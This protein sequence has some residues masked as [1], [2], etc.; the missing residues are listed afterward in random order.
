MKK[1]LCTIFF[2]TASG[3]AADQ[4]PVPVHPHTLENLEACIVKGVCKTSYP[5]KQDNEFI[6]YDIYNVCDQACCKNAIK[7]LIC[8]YPTT[9]IRLRHKVMRIDDQGSNIFA[10]LKAGALAEE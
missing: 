3:Y 1:I 9:Y 7:A 2:L 6:V 5:C 10:G 8:K 4:T